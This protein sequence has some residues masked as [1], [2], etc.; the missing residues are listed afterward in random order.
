MARDPEALELPESQSSTRTFMQKNSRG[1]KFLYATTWLREKNWLLVVRQEKSDA[2]KALHTATY[3]VLLVSVLGGTAIILAA[4]FLTGR[5]VSRM[6]RADAEKKDLG[7]Q[8]IRASRLAELGEMAAGFAHEINN[9]LQIIRSEQALIE[10]I[11]SDLKEAGG[12]KESKDLAEL[13]D[14]LG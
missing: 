6:K 14:S 12:L 9:P 3:L 8:L 4:F 2:F 10:A 11:L 1:E 7:E 5:I 13:E